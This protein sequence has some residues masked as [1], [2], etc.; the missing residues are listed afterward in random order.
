MNLSQNQKQVARRAAAMFAIA[1][2][3]AAFMLS[4][5]ESAPRTSL[6]DEYTNSPFAVMVS[7]TVVGAADGMKSVGW[8]NPDLEKRVDRVRKQI[9]ESLASKTHAHLSPAVRINIMAVR[10]TAYAEARDGAWSE[11]ALEGYL[12][13][14]ELTNA[15]YMDIRLGDAA[16]SEVGQKG[17]DVIMAALNRDGHE[18]PRWF[19][20]E[21]DPADQY[22]RL[23]L[24]QAISLEYRFGDYMSPV[25][26]RQFDNPQESVNAY[27]AQRNA[28]SPEMLDGWIAASGF[29][30]PP[31]I[32]LMAASLPEPEKDEEPAPM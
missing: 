11:A 10:E 12:R 29:Y 28:I 30:T 4:A 7:A 1:G 25:Y 5:G 32:A 23:A 15:E 2:T 20:E 17:Y 24:S 26:E 27:N 19:L 21:N 31:E 22:S 9:P 3:A 14:T 6:A 13:V 8:S 18:V 16:E